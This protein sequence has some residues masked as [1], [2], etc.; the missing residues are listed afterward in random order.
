MLIL[1][2]I[3]Y[4]GKYICILCFN[5]VSLL[6]NDGNMEYLENSTFA[7][8]EKC[9]C[10]YFGLSYEDTMIHRAPTRKHSNARHLILLILH[11]EFKMSVPV[12]SKHYGYTQRWI[13]RTNAHVRQQYEIYKEYKK[14][15]D[16]ITTVLLD[17][18]YA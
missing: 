13:K 16:M 12:L 4:I 15:Y 8:V 1:N 14:H 3:F 6:E 5:V 7:K 18:D 9:V 2:V 10:E 17:L 11:D